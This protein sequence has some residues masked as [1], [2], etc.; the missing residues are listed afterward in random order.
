MAAARR[1][2][3]AAV[4]AVLV[5]AVDGGPRLWDERGVW[6]SPDVVQLYPWRKSL[7]IAVCLPKRV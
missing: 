5:C 1:A 7:R 2:L 3:V 4:V 6:R